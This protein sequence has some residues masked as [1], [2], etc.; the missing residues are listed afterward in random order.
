VWRD[1]AAVLLRVVRDTG[2]RFGM[3]VILDV[4]QGRRG[5]N[6]TSR[7]F[8]RLSCHGT[9]REGGAVS[10]D[11]HWTAMFHALAAEPLVIESRVATSSSHGGFKAKTF[12][13]YGIGRRG[14]AV[15]EDDDSPR[16][17][18]TL[19]A[20]VEAE[21]ARRASV[22]GVEVDG[23]VEPSLSLS[24]EE[25]DLMQRLRA[26]R[27]RLAREHG[28]PPYCVFSE[29]TLA[30]MA[31]LKPRDAAA[32]RAVHGV[33]EAKLARFGQAFL[34]TIESHGCSFFDL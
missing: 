21:C 15:L 11:L 5:A 29:T 2:G 4:A 33:G 9:A 24:A 17:R 20:N 32:L 23:D 31:R 25:H 1:D 22:R 12:T 8:D 6:V 10:S 26:C 3:R 14:R 13:T 30:Q 34:V 28:L 18:L 16:L 19:P 27:K 7:G